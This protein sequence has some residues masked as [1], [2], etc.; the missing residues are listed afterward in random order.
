MWVLDPGPGH[1]L[2]YVRTTQ[3]MT[4]VCVCVCVYAG[5][6]CVFVYA[7]RLS[8]LISWE[9]IV[10][11]DHL[12]YSQGRG[13]A[14]VSHQADDRGLRALHAALIPAM[15]ASLHRPYLCSIYSLSDNN[16]CLLSALLNYIFISLLTSLKQTSIVCRDFKSMWHLLPEY[17]GIW[18][19]AVGHNIYY[20]FIS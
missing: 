6:V 7:G 20:V 1:G 4:M 16:K 12:E 10:S 3:D 5:G 2:S 8:K 11:L 17:L 18:V 19:K 14:P 15:I 13:V 9:N